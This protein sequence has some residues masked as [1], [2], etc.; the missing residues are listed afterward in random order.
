MKKI[1]LTIFIIL[2]IVSV[3]GSVG[4]FLYKKYPKGI[5]FTNYETSCVTK[6][7]YEVRGES[8]QGI[9]ANGEEITLLKGYYD[10]NSI[11]KGHVVVYN[12]SRNPNPIIKIVK[13]LPGDTFELK[14]NESNN[15]NI[16]INNEISANSSGQPYELSEARSKMLSL[17]IKDYKGVIPEG[18]FIILGNQL[19]GS[20]D[21][22]RFGLASQKQ[23]IGKVNLK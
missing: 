18:T 9:V 8:L 14:K 16:V 3:L 13:A 6:E 20:L 12:Y 19:S 11:E 7:K 1:F 21:S 5:S 4:Y 23:I 2:V 17:Y 10:C 15:F 22:T